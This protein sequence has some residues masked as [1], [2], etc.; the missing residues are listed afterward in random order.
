[1]QN[2]MLSQ[3]T[4]SSANEAHFGSQETTVQWVEITPYMLPKA[5]M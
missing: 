3:A 2:N 1:M 5:A 4:L